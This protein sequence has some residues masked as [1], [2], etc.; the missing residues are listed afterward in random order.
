MILRREMIAA[1]LY[2]KDP[3]WVTCKLLAERTARWRERWF[4]TQQ[5]KKA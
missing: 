5:N 3:S 2:E 4:E 1:F